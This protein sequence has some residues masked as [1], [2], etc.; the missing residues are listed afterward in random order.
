MHLL[1][2]RTL[3]LTPNPN[4]SHR[5]Q[6]VSTIVRIASILFHRPNDG[7]HAPRP[8]ATLLDACLLKRSSCIS[9]LP[10]G[11][12]HLYLFRH[13]TRFAFHKSTFFVST[14]FWPRGIY[15]G[16]ATTRTFWPPHYW[17]LRSLALLCPIVKTISDPGRTEV[18]SAFRALGIALSD[19]LT[20]VQNSSMQTLERPHQVGAYKADSCWVSRRPADH[21]LAFC[22]GS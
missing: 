9:T 10:N 20:Q 17:I 14:T 6:G 15:T 4:L 18:V 16:P 11:Q 5:Y 13:L 22:A 1:R 7:Q 12:V 3:E 8:R 19:P 21:L 2:K